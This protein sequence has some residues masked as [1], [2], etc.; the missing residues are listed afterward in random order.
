M[1][2]HQMILAELKKVG[3]RINRRYCKARS[4]WPIVTP[5]GGQMQEEDSHSSVLKNM[6][7]KPTRKAQVAELW[8]LQAT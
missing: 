8:I 6:F 1:T 2:D 3:A 7:K 5:K 4:I